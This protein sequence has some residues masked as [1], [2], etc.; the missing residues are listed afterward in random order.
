MRSFAELKKS[1]DEFNSKIAE[2]VK[3]ANSYQ[4][5]KDPRVWYPAVDAAGNGVS[6]VRFL[7]P[8]PGE[9]EAFVRT[10][11]HFFKGP[12]GMWYNELSLTTLGLPDPCSEYNN[13]L[14]NT[15]MEANK[16]QASAQKRKTNYYTNVH[17]INDALNP[18]NNG[19]V[20]I[21]KFGPTIYDFIKNKMVPEFSDQTPLPVFDP[22]AGANFR[23]R[24][25]KDEHGYR[26]Y[27]RSE[28]DLPKPLGDDAMIEEVWNQQH[29]LQAFKDPKLF[30]SY[31]DLKTRLN[32]VLGLNTDSTAQESAR[33]QLNETPAPQP[34][35]ETPP[36]AADSIADEEDD[37]NLNYFSKLARED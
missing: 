13:K 23:I 8:P 27:D 24:I 36:P 26:K 18:E 31:D 15:D 11:S 7:P 10:W 1:A 6:V 37:D 34:H 16:K 21:F 22:W 28:F 5:D 35:R 19:T 4:D 17:V 20:K 30:K 32:R 12:G 3:T 14:W 9:D 33:E 2:S 29:S 25:R